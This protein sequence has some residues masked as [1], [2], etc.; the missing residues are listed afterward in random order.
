[1]Y[2]LK[3]HGVFISISRRGVKP[4]KGGDLYTNVVIFENSSHAGV[5]V[6]INM[7]TCR[8]MWVDTHMYI[9]IYMYIYKYV[10]IDAYTRLFNY[11]CVSLYKFT[12]F[13]TLNLGRN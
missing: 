7:Y 3:E 12:S 2:H 5:S 6:S 1:M 10:H 8:H 13:S 9:Y 11:F 4:K